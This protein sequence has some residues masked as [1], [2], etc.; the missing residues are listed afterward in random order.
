[1]GKGEHLADITF[2]SKRIPTRVYR[3]DSIKNYGLK[4]QIPIPK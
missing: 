1:M 4:S 3:N 2:M